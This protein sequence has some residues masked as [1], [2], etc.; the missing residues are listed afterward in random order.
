MN[1]HGFVSRADSSIE[2]DLRLLLP[3]SLAS[4]GR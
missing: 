1:I 4:V 2:A 3:A